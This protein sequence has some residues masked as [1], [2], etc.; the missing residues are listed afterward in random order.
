MGNFLEGLTA[1]TADDGP[2][3]IA[4]AFTIKKKSGIR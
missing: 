4:G 1:H 3:S 2:D